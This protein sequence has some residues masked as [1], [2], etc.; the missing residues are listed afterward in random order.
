M[1]DK[2]AIIN[3]YNHNDDKAIL[4]ISTIK[5]AQKHPGLYFI[6]VT[7]LNKITNTKYNQQISGSLESI[8]WIY[9]HKV[10]EL[11]VQKLK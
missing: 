3:K 1:E 7:Y 9:S 5:Q 4:D 11:A 8:N 6:I 10:H 2:E